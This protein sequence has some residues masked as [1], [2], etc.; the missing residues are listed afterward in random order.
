MDELGGPSKKPE[1]V[2]AK[3]KLIE[4]TCSF[5]WR[6]Q[7]CVYL[8]VAS[9]GAISKTAEACADDG[10]NEFLFQLTDIRSRWLVFGFCCG[11]RCGD[12]NA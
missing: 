5:D 4:Q 7:R 8:S 6:W 9:T 3:K 12:R 10:T 1:G 2:A 11:T